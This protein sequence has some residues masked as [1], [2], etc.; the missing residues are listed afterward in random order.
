MRSGFPS[1]FAWIALAA[2]VVQLFGSFLLFEAGSEG[3]VEAIYL[4]LARSYSALA[5]EEWRTRGNVLLGLTCFVA[6]VATWSLLVGAVATTAAGVVRRRRLQRR[7]G[8][9]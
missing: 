6:S 3:I 4:P 1:L 5:P 8:G 7:Y 2:F 9:L